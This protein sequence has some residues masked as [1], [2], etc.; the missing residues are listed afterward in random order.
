M[1]KLWLELVRDVREAF[2][3][4]TLR[5]NIEKISDIFLANLSLTNQELYLIINV[6]QA[7]SFLVPHFKWGYKVMSEKKPA[8]IQSLNIKHYVF[9]WPCVCLF[10]CF[11]PQGKITFPIHRGGQT[12]LIQL[13]VQSY[14]HKA[15]F[16]YKFAQNS[17]KKQFE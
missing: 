5:F 1:N 15:I 12:F 8:K 7:F 4:S 13:F 2:S 9:V 14:L 10:N 16:L 3:L 11:C 6:K 17:V